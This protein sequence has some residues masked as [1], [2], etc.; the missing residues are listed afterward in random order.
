MR[1]RGSRSKVV[2]V[3]GLI[4]GV[5][6][7]RA[8]WCPGKHGGALAVTTTLV[9]GT[10]VKRLDYTIS[11]NGIVPLSGSTPVADP[12]AVA[13]TVEEL[14]PGQGY[15]L[16]QW[17]AS[18]DGKTKC[19]RRERFDITLGK[20]TPLSVTLLCRGAPVAPPAFKPE[21]RAAVRNAEG[22]VEVTEPVPA[23]C[24]SCE[25]ANIEAGECAPEAGCDKLPPGEDRALCVNLLNC[26]RATN[27]WI[28]DPSDCYCG[29]FKDE[30][31]LK[32]ADGACKAEIEAATKATD[33]LEVGGLFFDPKVPS[34]YAA[35]L[36]SCDKE[37]CLDHCAVK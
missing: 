8:T 18:P 25:K 17:A 30:R 12:A 32:G 35:R 5:L 23:A 10:D 24:T 20:T 14:A 1:R 28:R 15:L 11:G 34:G 3:L 19:V 37:K 13:F 29:T 36:I 33:T 9:R 4:A 26:M 2:M 16:D 21:P 27:C 31:C 22:V 6:L 7:L